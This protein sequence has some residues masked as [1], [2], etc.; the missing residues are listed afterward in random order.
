MW[1]LSVAKCVGSECV[2]GESAWV[3]RVCGH[4]SWVVS[5]WAS[6]C[7]GSEWVRVV[8][9]W[10]ASECVGSECVGIEFVGR[11]WMFQMSVQ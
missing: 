4:G 7:V 9:V 10:S 2:G 6:E 5:V 3:V 1:A 8:S 11:Q